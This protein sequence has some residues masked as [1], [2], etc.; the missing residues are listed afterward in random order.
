[1]WHWRL[2]GGPWLDSETHEAGPAHALRRT[3][4]DEKQ[5]RERMPITEVQV[6]RRSPWLC[7]VQLLVL[8][9]ILS[10]ACKGKPGEKTFPFL[11][12]YST[13]SSNTDL[14]QLQAEDGQWVMP[15]K[16]YAS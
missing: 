11:E 2:A 4:E 9:A 14:V 12:H 1:M 15:A 6:E 5:E 3:A 10:A 13:S 8:L 7:A 16:N